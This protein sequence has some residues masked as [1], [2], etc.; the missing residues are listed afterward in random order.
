MSVRTTTA[1]SVF[2][3]S[4]MLPAIDVGV[5]AVGFVTNKLGV[6]WEVRR[7]QDIGSNAISTGAAIDGKE[8]RQRWRGTMALG[9]PFCP[10][11]WAPRSRVVLAVAMVTGA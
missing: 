4:T 1:L 6:C 11:R 2:D 3:V 7:F 9:I 10:R 5:G 8:L